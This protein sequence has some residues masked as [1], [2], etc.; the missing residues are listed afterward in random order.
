MQLHAKVKATFEDCIVSLHR[1][2][3]LPIYLYFIE[4]RESR[5]THFEV[6]EDDEHMD[7]PC[8]PFRQSAQVTWKELLSR[9]KQIS[10]QVNANLCFS[11]K[12]NLDDLAMLSST[13]LLVEFRNKFEGIPQQ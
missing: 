5:T 7:T 8:T 6:R 3:L 13:L 10:D 11:Y 4:Q 2:S 1:H 9:A 12:L